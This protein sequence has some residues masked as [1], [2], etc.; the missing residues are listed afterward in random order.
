MKANQHKSTLVHP[1]L[2]Y[3][4]QGCIFETR[5]QYGPGHKEAVYQKILKEKLQKQSL[6]VEKEKKI[7]IYSQDSGEIVGTYQPDLIV[8]NIV[9]MELK[10]SSFTTK[11]DERQLYHYLRNSQYE[12]GYLVNF[13]SPRLYIK[14]IVYSNDRKPHLTI[15]V[16][17]LSHSR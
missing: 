12:L 17:S 14:R 16:D 6:Y 8:E 13:S 1:E 15:R 4:I 3:V 5:N 9:V 11:N 7:N 2:S 10:S